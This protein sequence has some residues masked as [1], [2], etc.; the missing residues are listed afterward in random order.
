MEK[1]S[2]AKSKTVWFNVLS[3]AAALLTASSG[4]IPPPALPYVMAAQGAI[5]VA[6]RFVT[7]QPIK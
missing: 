2:P 6:L 7:T 5:N 1:K 3:T 4:L